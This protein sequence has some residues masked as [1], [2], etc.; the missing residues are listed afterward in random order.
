MPSIN[1]TEKEALW[2]KPKGFIK[3]YNGL[4]NKRIKTKAPIR[5]VR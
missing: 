4:K 1:F 2:H 5:L 3:K